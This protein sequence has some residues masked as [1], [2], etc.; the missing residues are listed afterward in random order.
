MKTKFCGMLLVLGITFIG[1]KVAQAQQ[2]AIDNFKAGAY[3]KS[4][5]NE[6]ETAYRSGP[7]EDIIGGV[8]QTFFKAGPSN[9]FNQPTSL[10]IEANGSMIID[11]GLKSNWGLFPIGQRNCRK[12]FRCQ[13]N[14]RLAAAVVG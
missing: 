8:R 12:R 5:R 13:I 6:E 9:E 10:N 4:L 2:L 7:V 3:Q 11:S 14:R 1:S